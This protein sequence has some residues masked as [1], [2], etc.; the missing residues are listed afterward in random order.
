MSKNFTFDMAAKSGTVNSISK[1]RIKKEKPMLKL[2]EKQR[3][4]PKLTQKKFSKQLGSPD[5]TIKRYS[6][7]IEL[8][9]PYN[10]NKNRKENIEPNPS[11]TQTQSNTK[12]QKTE[13]KLK[14]TF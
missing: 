14:R 9:S 3:N 6:D 10:R 13:K 5:S 1:F 12:N 11:I 7:V 4:E 8:D 2:M